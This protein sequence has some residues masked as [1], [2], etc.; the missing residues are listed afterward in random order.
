MFY[1]SGVSTSSFNMPN[2]SLNFADL[3]SMDLSQASS[4][5]HPSPSPPSHPQHRWGGKSPKTPTRR[6]IKSPPPQETPSCLREHISMGPNA[7]VS[8]LGSHSIKSGPM[9][10]NASVTT[11]NRIIWV[12]AASPIKAATDQH[13][14]PLL[15]A[16][17]Q[18]PYAQPSSEQGFRQPSYSPGPPLIY[19]Q[20]GYPVYP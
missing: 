7:D 6:H 12:E 11:S 10:I 2:W 4:N 20:E 13:S 15:A 8:I 18:S 16:W 3:Y 14:G 19:S 17:S 9:E 1:V 5:N